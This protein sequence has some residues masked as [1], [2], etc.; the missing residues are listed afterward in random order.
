MKA[1][2]VF[3]GLAWGVDTVTPSKPAEPSLQAHTT[4]TA[5]IAIAQIQPA[6]G[7]E[8]SGNVEF[9]DK[10]KMHVLIALANGPSGS[11]L[12]VHL[13]DSNQCPEEALG[14]ETDSGKKLR[15]LGNVQMSK[16]GVGTLEREVR[17]I[18]SPEDREGLLHRAVVVQ[19]AKQTKNNLV[20]A[21]GILQPGPR[22]EV[23]P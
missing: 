22:K 12:A 2:L 7:S 4:D 8:V 14:T 6:K 21:C 23:R 13:M 18:A 3:V 20:L 9:H 16:K 1:L 15:H 5:A 11:R 17:E 10:G 19:L